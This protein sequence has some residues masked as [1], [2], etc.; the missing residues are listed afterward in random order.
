MSKK[1]KIKPMYSFRLLSFNTY[2]EE[3][4]Q[5]EESNNTQLNKNYTIQMFGI[6]EKGETAS[7]YVNNF[8]PYFYIKVNDDW[9]ESKMT[10]FLSQIKEDMGKYYEG[11]IEKASFVKKKKL[12]GFDGGKHHTF[13]LI[14]FK[15]EAA[16]TKAKNLWYTTKTT[17]GQY[18]KFLTKE[19]YVCRECSTNTYIYE[20][21]IPP[22]LRMFHIKEIVH[23]W[24]GL[25]T[26]KAT[27]IPKSCK[28]DTH[29]NLQ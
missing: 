29:M 8:T 2:D 1:M 24:V 9:N 17:K 28:N 20:A 5:E 10:M 14:K 15:N 12:Y 19:G 4:K 13:I 6:N 23:L 3:D 7:I 25:P 11:S 18:K 21:Q 26:K 22:F 16:M 27:K